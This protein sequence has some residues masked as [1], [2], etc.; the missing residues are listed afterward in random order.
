MN[1][2][3]NT[4][5]DDLNKIFSKHQDT[6]IN[7]KSLITF[8]DDVMQKNKKEI[9]EFRNHNL[10]SSEKHFNMDDEDDIFKIQTD[11]N[12]KKN[13]KD[14]YFNNVIQE[15]LNNDNLYCSYLDYFDKI[16]MKNKSSKHSF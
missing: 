4:T 3:K 12:V 15:T 14:D 2:E 6:E 8:N 11:K 16:W 9:E 5:D 13:K 10:I 1:F 7:K